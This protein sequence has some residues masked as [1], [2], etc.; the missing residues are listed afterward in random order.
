MLSFLHVVEQLLTP[1]IPV[2]LL[3]IVIIVGAP[4]LLHFILA[5]SATYIESPAV[6]LLGP[7]NAGKTALLT[8]F[9]RGA[10][11]A[12]T[13]TSQV[14]HSIELNA[15]TDSLSKE[16]FRNH[17]D[18]T[19]TH[20]KFRLIDTPGHGKLRPLAMENLSQ[21]KMLKAIVFVVDAA[22]LSEQE[23]LSPT[24]TYLYDVLL[25]LQRRASA[26][27]R[28]RGAAA[29]PVLVA[30]NKMDLFT[31]LPAAMV[32][33]RLEKE[34]GRIRLSR[35]KRLLDSDADPDGLGVDE[36]E[37]WLGDYASDEFCFEQ[38]QEIGISVQVLPGSVTA[39]GA[40]ADTWW[41]WIAQRV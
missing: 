34:L 8:L 16:S 33:T 29:T 39:E 27:S 22:T 25:F 36:Q 24:A 18:T 17:H 19:G 28:K 15:S 21:S 12:Q 20:S 11:A 26:K 14:V 10:K 30:A 3:G 6:I 37:T 2:V 5:S 9:E 23:M 41:W 4:L 1:S 35:S 38:L 32:K 7:S 31:A 13:H 40:D